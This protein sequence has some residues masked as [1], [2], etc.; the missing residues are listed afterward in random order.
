MRCSVSKQG[1][2]AGVPGGSA[3]PLALQRLD[4]LLRP[5]PLG[6][7][8]RCSQ[9]WTELGCSWTGEEA[10]QLGVVSQAGGLRD[11]PG[12]GLWDESLRPV[13]VPAPAS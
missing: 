9:T 5:F 3:Q 4:A 7:S 11:L 8:P 13:P 10:P 12:G 2:Q 6:A 1:A